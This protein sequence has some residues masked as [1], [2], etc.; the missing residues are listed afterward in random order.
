MFQVLVSLVYE[1][2][3]ILILLLLLRLYVK[4]LISPV[5]LALASLHLNK[6][7]KWLKLQMGLS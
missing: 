5:Q 7:M 6:Q 3:L 4:I 1:V 2:K